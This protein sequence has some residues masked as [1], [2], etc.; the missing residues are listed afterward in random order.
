MIF[1]DFNDWK[2]EKMHEIFEFSELI[3]PTYDEEQ[4]I[5]EMIRKKS[6]RAA[7][8]TPNTFREEQ[9]E[10]FNKLVE[11]TKTQIASHWM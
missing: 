8:T 4:I 3:E 10:K 5:A 2:P 6:L 7:Q 1:G 11:T 9:L